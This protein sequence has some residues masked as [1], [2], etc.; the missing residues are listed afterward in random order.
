[1]KNYN[2]SNREKKFESQTLFSIMSRSQTQLSEILEFQFY[3]VIETINCD[4][5]FNF[6]RF[7]N[8]CV[9]NMHLTDLSL[10]LFE[11]ILTQNVLT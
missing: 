6:S 9:A 7:G 11:L 3:M 10:D 1:M 5:A 8:P 4:V 2:N